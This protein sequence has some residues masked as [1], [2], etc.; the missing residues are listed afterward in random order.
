MLWKSHRV[1]LWDK[2]K[3]GKVDV[4]RVI[5]LVQHSGRVLASINWHQSSFGW[6]LWRVLW[7]VLPLWMLIP[8]PR[9]GFLGEAAIC[10]SSAHPSLQDSLPSPPFCHCP[11]AVTFIPAQES[12]GHFPH[13]TPCTVLHHFHPH[14]HLL[15]SELC[16]ALPFPKAES[17]PAL[18]GPPCSLLQIPLGRLKK[19]PEE[20]PVLAGALPGRWP[21]KILLSLC[22][23]SAAV[24][25]DADFRVSCLGQLDPAAAPVP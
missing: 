22:H 14:H 5:S 18:P 20:L 6:I 16:P 24:L 7:D 2:N 15:L 10:P 4:P 8:W 11:F 21:Q 12:P 19:S 25:E 1:L 13:S 23:G 9:A 3:E 17:Q